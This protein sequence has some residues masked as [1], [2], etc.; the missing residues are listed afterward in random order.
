MIAHRLLSDQL[1]G[2]DQPTSEQ[3]RYTARVLFQG[4]QAQQLQQQGRAVAVDY[5]TQHVST[6]ADHLQQ[7]RQRRP[8]LD[9][10]L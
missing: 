5:V 8:D 6:A 2:R 3:L 1:Q 4:P 9:L 10:S 7:S